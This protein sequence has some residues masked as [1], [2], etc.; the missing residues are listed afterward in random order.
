MCSRRTG[1]ALVLLVAA[2]WLGGPPQDARAVDTYWNVAS[3]NWSA[4]GSWSAGE[5]T[6]ADNAFISNGGTATITASGETARFL[7]LGDTGNGSVVM[8]SGDLLLQVGAR[9]GR[10]VGRIGTFTLNGGSLNVVADNQLQVGRDGAQ[11][12]FYQNNGTVTVPGSNS[13]LFV[14]PYGTG[15][16]ELAG[17]TLNSFYTGVGYGGNFQPN[18]PDGIGQFVQ[19]GGAHTT[20]QVVVGAG[21][22]DGGN[23]T[24]TLQNGT[25]TT[26]E[27]YIA[28]MDNARGSGVRPL[29]GVF[30]QSG[31]SVT[32]STYLQIGADLTF[33][34]N[35]GGAGQGTY[36]F[37]GGTLTDGANNANMTVRLDAPARGTFQGKGVVD[38]SG[39]LTN[40]GRVI[41]D[42]GTLDLSHFASVT[43]TVENVAANGSTNNGWF[44]ING[45]KLELPAVAVSASGPYNW[46]ESSGDAQI[47]LVNSVRATL[48]GVTG[49]GS[50]DIDLYGPSNPAVPST[51]AL[52]NVL[53]VWDIHLSGVSFTTADLVFRYDDS[54]TVREDR[55]A[56]FRLSG[57]DWAPVPFS[58]DQSSNLISAAG[59]TSLS[60]FAVS[61]VPE[62]ASVGLAA[63]ALAALGW[64]GW[65]RRRATR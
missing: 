9:I 31:G 30:S 4:P 57:G 22:D 50:L 21:W 48:N 26:D 17:G 34:N 15:R 49:S 11:G 60:W 45:G 8:N 65:R 61:E 25:F 32:I 12:F 42:G 47:D 10:G 13:A 55:L 39:V 40:N 54:L 36:N 27:L 51:A 19:T 37:T 52:A 63:L 33:L 5:P 29:L 24:Y 46:G 2:A 58:L 41:A 43:S 18:Q 1:L 38:L 35:P 7:V 14:G 53:G 6:S 44:A 59:L 16:Y 62:P 56:L 23:G 28:T 64:Y 20:T 3:G